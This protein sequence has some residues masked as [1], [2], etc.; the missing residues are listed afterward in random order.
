ME[1]APGK[2]ECRSN[3]SEPK[4]LVIKS[5]QLISV[6]ALSILIM[7]FGPNTACAENTVLYAQFSHAA[8]SSE[9]QAALPYFCLQCYQCV[10]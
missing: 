3:S 7:P 1:T 10:C 4:H 9:S 5:A 8:F 6:G 2:P